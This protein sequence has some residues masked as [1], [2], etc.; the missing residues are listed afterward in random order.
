MRQLL[1]IGKFYPWTDEHDDE[2]RDA[3]EIF[4]KVYVCVMF[5]SKQKKIKKGQPSRIL[6]ESIK[7]RVSFVYTK[8]LKK[9]FKEF[10]QCKYIM[11]DK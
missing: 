5:D 4:D 3:L 7:D 2:L 9:V 1:Y 10:K 6:D 8:S 11:F